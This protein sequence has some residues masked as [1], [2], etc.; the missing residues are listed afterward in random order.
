MAFLAFHQMSAEVVWEP[1]C[2]IRL[3]SFTVATNC[4]GQ[5]LAHRDGNGLLDGSGPP[6]AT[7]S[8]NIG[9]VALFWQDLTSSVAGNLIEGQFPNSGGGVSTCVAGTGPVLTLTTGTTFVGDYF[10]VGKIGHGTFVYV[11]EVSGYNWYGLSTFLAMG[12]SGGW[13]SSGIIPVIQSY[14]IDKK[15]DDGL[16]TTGAVQAMFL[17]GSEGTPPVQS[18]NAATDSTTTC[19]NTTSNAYSIGSLADYGAHGNCAL[20]FRFQ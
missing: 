15:I 3:V 20:S 1:T 19:Y 2:R 9:E 11:Y 17:N 18:T 7:Y 13:F 12:P 16:P 5:G 6:P 10:P 8:E 14:N 4:N